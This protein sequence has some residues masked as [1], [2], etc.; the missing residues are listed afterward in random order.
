MTDDEKITA[1]EK[2]IWAP[3]GDCPDLTPQE[4]KVLLLAS[5]GSPAT[6][7]ANHLGFSRQ[8]FYKVINRAIPKLRHFYD[9]PNLT[10]GDLPSF[11]LERIE[12]VLK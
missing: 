2:L 5:R 3:Y 12:E 9:R 1:I 7:I 6:R 8:Y 11:V 4:R 10:L